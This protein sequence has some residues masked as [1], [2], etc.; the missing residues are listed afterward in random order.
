MP[1]GFFL[2]LALEL[3]K[4]E[5]QFTLLLHQEDSCMVGVVVD[6]SDVVLAYVDHRRL[7]WS[8]YIRVEQIQETSTYVAFLQEWKL[9]LF[10]EL[11]CITHLDN[12]HCF[13]GWKFDDHSL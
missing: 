13:K 12:L 5:K 2:H 4:V 9:T 11:I 1:T 7:S 8:P 6:E 10:V 3:L